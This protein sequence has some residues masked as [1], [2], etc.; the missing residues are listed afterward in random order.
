MHRIERLI[1]HVLIVIVVVLF[2][3]GIRQANAETNPLVTEE[4]IAVAVEADL[5]PEAL[6]GAVF[7]TG[8]DPREYAY[9]VGHLKRPLVWSIWDDLAICEADGKWDTNTGNGYY[10]GIQ[11]D[12]TFWRKHGGLNFAQRADLATRE[13]QI[14]V[15]KQGQAVQGW[16]AWPTCAR[17]LRLI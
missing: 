6:Q 10:G 12:M 2:A 3:L 4:T 7:T 16:K 1:M 13:Q 8:L 9:Q 11:A 14:V 5:D 15:A 17:R